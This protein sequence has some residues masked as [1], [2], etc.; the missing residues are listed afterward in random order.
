MT[1]L[2]VSCG[3]QQSS[4]STLSLPPRKQRVSSS[5]WTKP[6]RTPSLV[7]TPP[8]VQ[9][10]GVVGEGPCE[11]N[12]TLGTNYEQKDSCRL[13]WQSRSAKW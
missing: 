1:T 3:N 2:R 12:L 8:G 7:E 6:L 13:T 4:K 9:G 11:D 5:Q 10:W